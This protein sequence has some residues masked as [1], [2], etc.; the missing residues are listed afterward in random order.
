MQRHNNSINFEFE[1][2]F[3]FLFINKL[4]YREQGQ[5]ALLLQSV[6]ILSLSRFE[7]GVKFCYAH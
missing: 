7:F 2:I 5:F 4:L 6:C 3:V 1:S